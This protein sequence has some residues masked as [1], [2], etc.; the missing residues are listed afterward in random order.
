[1]LHGAGAKAAARGG[2]PSAASGPVL[3]DAMTA[4]L[5]RAF[6]SLGKGDDKQAPPYFLSYSVSDANM[7]SIRA[8]YGALV[9]S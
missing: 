3:L 9:D 2:T 5:Q 8:Q 4:E 6:T 7:V 1:M